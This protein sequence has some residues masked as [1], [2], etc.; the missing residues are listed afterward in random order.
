[1]KFGK[2]ENPV[3]E[4]LVEQIQETLET[5]E[6]EPVEQKT[7]AW[8]GLPI[9][10]TGST[11]LD[12]AISGGRIYKGGIPACIL[13]EVHGPSGSGKTSILSEIGSSAQLQGGEVM[14][15]D[16]EA[17]MDREYA[18]IYGIELD[19]SNYHRP[20]TVEEVFKLVKKWK[21]DKKPK[22]L[23]TDSLAALTTDLELS[24]KGD[25][26]GM[27]RAKEFSSG[28]RVNARLIAE[29]LWVC[30]NQER[31][32][33]N[34]VVTP[35]GKA[36]PYYSSLRVRCKQ[37]KRIEID[38]KFLPKSFLQSEDAKKLS[39]KELSKEGVEVTQSIG[40]CSECFVTKSTIDDPYR[41][42]LIYVVAGYGLDDVRGNLQYLKDM[43]KLNGY[44][45]P[46]GKNYMGM[47]QAIQHIEEVGL[48][49]E[50]KDQTIEIWHEVQELFRFN[51]S[52]KK[53]RG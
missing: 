13:M 43:M 38:K 27:R 47:D 37:I 51:R 11:L 3:Q 2:K 5:E 15:Q 33:D 12:L 9:V 17:R 14:Y 4:N 24:D 28:F 1:M 6:Y 45:T 39:K 22:T 40:I 23:L 30:S 53:I 16:P 35:G 19:K 32:G 7:I 18:R 21:T 44:P 26:M 48:H 25:K 50:L 10:S 36:I 41:S 52:R 20:E 31:E 34:G 46:D 42:A 8:E 29:M 49:Q